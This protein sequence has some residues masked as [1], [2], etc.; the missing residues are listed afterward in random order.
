[1]GESSET[2]KQFGNRYL[3]EDDNVFKHNAWDDVKWDEEQERFALESVQQNSAVAMSPE[4]ALKYENE[5]DSNWNAFYDIHQNKFFKDRHWLFTEFPELKTSQSAKSFNIFEIGCG[6]GN[7]ILPILK[8][9]NNHNLQVYGC[10]FSSRAIEIL[11]QNE[12]FNTKRCQ[13]FVLDVTN[14]NWQDNLPFEENSM[15]IIVMI[16]VLSA[17]KPDK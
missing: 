2:R 3:T 10:D 13:A 7:T 16:F 8:Y 1:M 15:D 14:E 9:N 6:V 11:Q 4:Q 12:N 17:I 5:A